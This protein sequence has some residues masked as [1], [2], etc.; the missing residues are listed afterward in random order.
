[1]ATIDRVAPFTVT[2][3]EDLCEIYDAPV[4]TTA[5]KENPMVLP[6]PVAPADFP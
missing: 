5:N 6:V 3:L 2:S 4:T 1:M